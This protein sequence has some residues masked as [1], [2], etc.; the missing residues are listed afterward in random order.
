MEKVLQKTFCESYVKTLRD[1]I[2]AGISIDDYFK[3]EFPYDKSMVKPLAGVYQPVGLVDKM[4][5]DD[6]LESAKVVYE[7]Y[8][9]ISPLLASNEN[10]WIYLTHVDLFSYVQKRWLDRRQKAWGCVVI[11]VYGTVSLFGS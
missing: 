2:V 5:P 7:A 1:R 4:N 3:N 10:F 6:D 11:E 8:K 9:N